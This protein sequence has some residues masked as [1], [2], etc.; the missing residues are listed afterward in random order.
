MEE[1]PTGEGFEVHLDRFEGPLTLLLYLIEKNN[2]DIFDI[3]IS[4]ITQEYLRYLYAAR[5]I[6]A[7]IAGEF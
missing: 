7:D 3:P 5:Q 1:V 6:K 4:T 2:L